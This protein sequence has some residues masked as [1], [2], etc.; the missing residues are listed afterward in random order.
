MKKQQ[1]RE[2]SKWYKIAY[3]S[4]S[5]KIF[6]ARGQKTDK[7]PNSGKCPAQTSQFLSCFHSSTLFHLS[8]LPLLP[9]L[10]KLKAS[11][12][13]LLTKTQVLHG[14]APQEIIFKSVCAL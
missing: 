7:S 10:K 4:E 5:V 3:G 2:S 12:I 6:W 14:M 11:D 1:S 13:V 9:H 8:L